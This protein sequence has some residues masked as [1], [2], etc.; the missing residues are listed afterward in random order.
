MTFGTLSPSRPTGVL[1]RHV[2]AARLR[3]RS[4]TTAGC[5]GMRRAARLSRSPASTTSASMRLA[6]AK[7]TALQSVRHWRASG[8]A[9]T[10]ALTSPAAPLSGNMHHPA[11]LVPQ[12]IPLLLHDL[13]RPVYA[14]TL[15]YGSSHPLADVHHPH[16][17]R[18]SCTQHAKFSALVQRETV[19][20]SGQAA[21]FRRHLPPNVQRHSQYGTLL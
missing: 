4:L 3:S 6:S 8:E 10:P 19:P 7:P 18:Q 14:I 15:T 9:A 11:S 13:S 12:G 17:R 16:H 1:P 5:G 20:H 2:T 21:P